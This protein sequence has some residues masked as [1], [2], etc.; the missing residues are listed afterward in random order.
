MPTLRTPSDL[1]WLHYSRGYQDR[2]R[3]RRRRRGRCRP[4]GPAWRPPTPAPPR[5]RSVRRGRKLR[6]GLAAQ[7]RRA[8]DHPR[9]E[10]RRRW[11]L[12][13]PWYAQT[14]LVRLDLVEGVSAERLC[15]KPGCANTWAFCIPGVILPGDLV[16]L[17]NDTPGRVARYKGD[18]S[19][20]TPWDT[21]EDRATGAVGGELVSAVHC[22]GLGGHAAFSSARP[23]WFCWRRASRS[24]TLRQASM[25][26]TRA[27]MS[28]S[29]TQPAR[30]R[31]A[32]DL[33]SSMT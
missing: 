32:S 4:R 25:C 22:G 26:L 33:P 27:S 29:S 20:L 2:R 6:N 8:G 7:G 3:K 12:R 15:R 21:T 30:T 28:R 9:G 1:R 23:S 11:G 5:Q 14:L 17:I 31:E 19:P 18:P 13:L 16:A 10:L 24:I